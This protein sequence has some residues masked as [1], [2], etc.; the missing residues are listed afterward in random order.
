VLFR[1]G[2]N[3]ER[4]YASP[5]T[6]LAPTAIGR[7]DRRGDADGSVRSAS[8]RFDGAALC[9]GMSL[10]GEHPAIDATPCQ[11]VRSPG[12]SGQTHHGGR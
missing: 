3:F 5:G 11:Q 10:A 9:G 6:T 2:I 4:R 7:P 12:L 1:L 8:C